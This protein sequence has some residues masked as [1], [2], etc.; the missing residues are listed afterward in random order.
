MPGTPIRGSPLG[1]GE[2]ESE[3]ESESEY[4][5]INPSLP[6]WLGNPRV[7]VGEDTD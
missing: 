1:E 3:S 4:R 5:H 7:S 6:V 2:S